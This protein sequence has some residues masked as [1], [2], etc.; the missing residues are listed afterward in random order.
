[1]A[2]VF[3][4]VRMTLRVPSF[5]FVAFPLRSLACYHPYCGLSFAQRRLK[6]SRQLLSSVKDLKTLNCVRVI[7]LMSLVLLLFL[8]FHADRD[9]PLDLLYLKSSLFA[10]LLADPHR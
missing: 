2:K 8:M 7:V 3:L 1:M 4:A 5:V 6:S 9:C 10:G